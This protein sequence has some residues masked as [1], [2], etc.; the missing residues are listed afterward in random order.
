MKNEE[1]G[2]TNIGCF[3]E[4][5]FLSRKILISEMELSETDVLKV[6]VLKFVNLGILFYFYVCKGDPDLVKHGKGSY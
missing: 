1:A 5:G 4:E 3:R 2:F 6:S